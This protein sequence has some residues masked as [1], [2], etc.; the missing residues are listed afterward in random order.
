MSAA[1]HRRKARLDEIRPHRQGRGA[2][3]LEDEG[4][5][6]GIQHE[7]DRDEHGPDV[8]AVARNEDPHDAP[9]LTDIRR[10]AV[11]TRSGMDLLD[12]RGGMRSAA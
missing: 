1:R 10:M 9:M 6:L 4:D 3:A 2:R 5:L 12:T 11:S 7:V 8:T